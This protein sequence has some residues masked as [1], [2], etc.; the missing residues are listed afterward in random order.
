MILNMFLDAPV[1]NDN[2][3]LPRIEIEIEGEQKKPPKSRGAK[4]NCL[5]NKGN[6]INYLRTNSNTK[7]N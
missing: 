5:K 3:L 6:K 7:R 4:Y 2:P 1:T